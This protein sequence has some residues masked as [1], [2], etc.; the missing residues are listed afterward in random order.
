MRSVF[1]LHAPFL[2]LCIA[3]PIVPLISRALTEGDYTYTTN[4]AG[5]ATITGFPISFAGALSI[6]NTLGGCPVTTIGY[7]AFGRCDHM[8]TVSIPNSVRII[9]ECA[10]EHCLNLTS[11]TIPA[12]VTEIGMEA[13]ASCLR[14]PSIN[15]PASVTNIG[16]KICSSCP[17]L[18]QITVDLSNPTFCSSNGVLF[19][20][21]CDNLLQ[22]PP[23]KQAGS[24]TIPE[25][26]IRI[27]ESAFG[28]CKQ[29][30][31]IV[32]GSNVVSIGKS[33]FDYCQNL[34][35]ITMAYG[36]ISIGDSAFAHCIGLASATISASVTSIGPRAF[37]S[38]GL[39]HI[40]IPDS[41]TNIGDFAFASCAHLTRVKIGT[42]ATTLGINVFGKCGSL[43][44][45]LFEGNTPND[46]TDTF[47]SCPGTV[48]VY[49]LPGTTG[50]GDTFGGRPTL[51]WNPTVQNNVDF[52]FAADRFGFNVVGTTNIPV[53]VE[54][55]TNLS[56]GSWTPL[57]TNTLGTSGLLYFSDPSSTNKPVRFYRIAWP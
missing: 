33:A 3:L 9:G 28:T 32:I 24:Y 12:G 40:T 1:S 48:T 57:L 44:G 55:T 25:S 11:I 42:N 30:T 34:S 21:A 51:C 19:T 15:I 41:V 13:F 4:A 20:K 23:G 49:Y 6:P 8:T 18:T 45:V 26:V 43:T 36:V 54:A 53:V 46:D 37:S 35:A 50:W 31:H 56:S 27:N 16:I 17:E 22:Y 29:L 38:S 5:Q 47:Y 7:S 39:T 10:F 52:G 2:S 14:L